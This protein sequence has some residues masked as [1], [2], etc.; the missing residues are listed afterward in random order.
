MVR[1]NFLP[2]LHSV[3]ISIKGFPTHAASTFDAFH[4][5]VQGEV[6][7]ARMYSKRG[8]THF[9]DECSV[10]FWFRDV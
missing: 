6:E 8:S 10:I 3:S 2:H 5:A 7:A 9:L 4:L 1:L